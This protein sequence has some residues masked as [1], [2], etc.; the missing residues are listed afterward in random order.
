MVS[1][2]RYES[3][4]SRLS[5]SDSRDPSSAFPVRVPLSSYLVIWRYPLP[6]R[7]TV[8]PRY[9]TYRFSPSFSRSP[10]RNPKSFSKIRRRSAPLPFRTRDGANFLTRFS[11]SNIRSFH[12]GTD[13]TYD[14]RTRNV[15][16]SR[17][18]F[19]HPILAFSVRPLSSSER[20][21]TPIQ[22]P[23]RPVNRFTRLNET[24]LSGPLRRDVTPFTGSA[25][26]ANALCRQIK[27]FSK[28]RKHVLCRG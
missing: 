20:I 7:L 2:F 1:G 10:R 19:L 17:S 12:T 15:R 11:F 16:D 13:R 23:F 5:L 28:R 26:P 25:F 4:L 21:A 6:S 9:V 18:I 22:N 27:Y 14:E 24:F 3:A 8:V